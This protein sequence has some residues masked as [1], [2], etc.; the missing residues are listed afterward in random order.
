[1]AASSNPTEVLMSDEFVTCAGCVLLRRFPTLQVCILYHRKEDRYIL[2]KGRKDRGE[3]I[4]EAALR[5]TYE[6]T[7]HRCSFLPLNMTTRSQLSSVFVKDQ[8]TYAPGAVEP[9]AVFLRRVADRDLK[10]IFWFVAEVDETRPYERG[11]QTGSED[12]ETRFVPA[13]EVL[14]VLTYACDREVVAKALELYRQT[15]PAN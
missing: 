15:Y 12:Y 14:D 1:M 5:E 11:T 10:L 2:P 6:E 4:E 9:I 7:G 3:S 8:P 13:D